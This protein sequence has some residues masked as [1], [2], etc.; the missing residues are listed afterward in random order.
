MALE[1][2]TDEKIAALLTMPKR[3]ENARAKEQQEAKHMRRSYHVVSTD[4]EQRF[5]LFTRQST[6]LA[7]GYTA[8]LQWHAKSGDDVMLMRCNGSDHP[9]ANPLEFERLDFQCHIHIATERYI[10]ANKKVEQY[11]T[12]T[13]A[14]RSVEGALHHIT[15]LAHIEG[16]TTAPD[17]PDLFLPS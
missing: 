11:A 7:D 1:T 12:S 2:L 4:G 8:G 16:L 14:Y 5:T 13:T 15:Q 3:V 10:A 6:K 17:E 9:H